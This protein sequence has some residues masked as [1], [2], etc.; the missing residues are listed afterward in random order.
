VGSW[1]GESCPEEVAFV[2]TLKDDGD[3]LV[4]GDGGEAVVVE[5]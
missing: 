2:Q 4:R 3:N 5:K 1:V